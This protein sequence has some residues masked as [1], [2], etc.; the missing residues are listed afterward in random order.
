MQLFRS[1]RS[2][3]GIAEDTRNVMQRMRR[4]EIWKKLQEAK[5]PFS[6]QET[7]DELVKMA[8]KRNLDLAKAP[9]SGK[10][11]VTEDLSIHDLRKQ[12]MGLSKAD[13]KWEWADIVKMS[14]EQL[15]GILNGDDP[16]ARG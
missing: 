10:P 14:K 16:S 2:D 15:R 4:R 5:I 9:A 13:G 7:K 3:L 12:V 6:G 11:V 1:G 8:V